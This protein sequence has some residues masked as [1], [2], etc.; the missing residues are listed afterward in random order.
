MQ[1]KKML[2]RNYSIGGAN[3]KEIKKFQFDLTNGL[4]IP[5]QRKPKPILDF[6]LDAPDDLIKQK[7]NNRLIKLEVEQISEEFF[8]ELP[9]FALFE[10]VK[11][12]KKPGGDRAQTPKAFKTSKS[13]LYQNQSNFQIGS[14]F[15]LDDNLNFKEMYL[16]ILEQKIYQPFYISKQTILQY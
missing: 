14:E 4:V 9:N 3:T 7:I 1:K 2:R 12:A 6:S 10:Q 11:S 8:E 5:D 13:L 16:V 15:C